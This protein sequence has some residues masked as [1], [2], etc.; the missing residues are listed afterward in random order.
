[1]SHCGDFRR[2]LG[3]RTENSDL[4]GEAVAT[5]REVLAGLSRE[6]APLHWA[7]VQNSLGKA[8]Q[9]LSGRG[10]GE[11]RFREA[12][13]RHRA[14]LLELHRKRGPRRWALVQSDLGD[15]LRSVGALSGEATFLEEAVVAYMDALEVLKPDEPGSWATVRLGLGQARAALAEKRGQLGSGLMRDAVDDYRD[16]LEVYSDESH[17]GLRIE[18]LEQLG[19][20]LERLGGWTDCRPYLEEAV[21]LYAEVA[22]AYSRGGRWRRWA[23]AQR[24]MGHVLVEVGRGRDG[25]QVEAAIVAH[26]RALAVY[27]RDRM[28]LTGPPYNEA[29]IWAEVEMD[30]GVAY[31][32][33]AQL[34]G[35][36]VYFR[37]AVEA[38]RAALQVQSRELVRADWYLTQLNLGVV[39]WSWN[40]IE[41]EIEKLEEAV[42]ALTAARDAYD[43]TVDPPEDGEVIVG[44]LASGQAA[45]EIWGQL[46]AR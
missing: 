17:S 16:A 11:A 32:A 35:G 21:D 42:E 2:L 19:V 30:L 44:L 10:N 5:H 23:N 38:F 34:T 1:M 4:L 24:N 3:E 18:I 27:T 13:A 28:E 15:A 29:L 9:S 36:G 33:M 20:A 6:L 43:A 26:Q 31:G 12:V 14:A 41:P 39:L 46:N 8:L 37:R 22:R 45:L 40:E 7:V 25:V